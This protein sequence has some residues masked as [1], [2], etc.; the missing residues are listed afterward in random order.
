ME[1]L[2]SLTTCPMNQAHVGDWDEEIG[3]YDVAVTSRSSSPVELDFFIDRQMAQSSQ[4]EERSY[5]RPL[6]HGN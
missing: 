2:Q 5:H 6:I 4:N 1:L 3:L